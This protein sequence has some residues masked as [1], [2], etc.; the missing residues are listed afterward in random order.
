MALEVL[1]GKLFGQTEVES[2][3]PAAPLGIHAPGA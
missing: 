1:A 3:G 2:D